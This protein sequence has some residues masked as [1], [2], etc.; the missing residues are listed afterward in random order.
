MRPWQ[1]YHERLEACF[2]HY[3]GGDESINCREWMAMCRDCALID[4]NTSFSKVL[5]IFL[6][7]NQVG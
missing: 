2:I 3:S 4:A 6:R 5:E 7:C 1:V